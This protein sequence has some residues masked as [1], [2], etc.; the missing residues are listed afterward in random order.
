MRLRGG[1][2]KKPCTSKPL[3]VLRSLFPVQRLL[4]NALPPRTET[5]RLT[6][7]R[8]RSAEQISG[9]GDGDVLNRGAQARQE[10][11]VLLGS[12]PPLDQHALAPAAQQT[13]AFTAEAEFGGKQNR[14]KQNQPLGDFFGSLQTC[15][16]TIL[17]AFIDYLVLF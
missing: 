6:V 2:E 16:P 15:S 11:L 14:G 5:L 9:R 8:V 12:V 4:S 7:V 10:L 1:R 13:A 17:T 3:P